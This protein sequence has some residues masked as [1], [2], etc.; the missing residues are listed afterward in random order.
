MNI[1][2]RRARSYWTSNEIWTTRRTEKWMKKILL[3]AHVVRDNCDDTLVHEPCYRTNTQIVKSWFYF[4]TYRCLHAF[5][6]TKYIF[7]KPFI[8]RFCKVFL[9]IWGG[10][11]FCEHALLQSLQLGAASK[12][13]IM[14]VIYLLLVKMLP[15]TSSY[16]IGKLQVADNFKRISS[17]TGGGVLI[18]ATFV[19]YDSLYGTFTWKKAEQVMTWRFLVFKKGASRNL[20]S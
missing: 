8:M 11:L 10:F 17:V 5:S 9:Y 16:M 20:V 18:A 14:F 12:Q 7:E 4:Y 6:K 13:R 3:S 2:F 1:S 15:S 19:Q